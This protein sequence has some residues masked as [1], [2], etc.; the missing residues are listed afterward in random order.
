[1]TDL[2]HFTKELAFFCEKDNLRKMDLECSELDLVKKNE[3]FWGYY[4]N[5]PEGSGKYLYF[6]H[7]LTKHP[8][9]F[10]TIVELGN[11]EGLST[12]AV[13]TA[14]SAEQTFTSVDIV[15]DLRYV[16]DSIKQ[17]PQ[18]YFQFGNCLSDS[19]LELIPNNIDLILFDTIHTY[20]QVSQEW[21]CYKPKLSD[22]AV[23]LI[24]DINF[25]DKRRI[26][27]ELGD[28]CTVLENTFMHSSGFAVVVFKRKLDK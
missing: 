7:L 26:L 25:G 13:A 2:L 12:L 3:E 11:R 14:L 28:E 16:P 24:D 4:R 1:M 15:R 5:I 17:S 20:K 18:V 10:K 19:C 9:R 21:I 27:D 8:E 23:V 6:M 22:E